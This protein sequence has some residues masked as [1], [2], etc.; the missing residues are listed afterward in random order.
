MTT[1]PADDSRHVYEPGDLAPAYATG[2]P[3]K[4]C[5]LPKRNKHVHRSARARTR[6]PRPT[7]RQRLAAEAD[8]AI[9]ARFGDVDE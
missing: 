9:K 5:G 8:A 1:P 2:V 4:H 7:R 3:C 6:T